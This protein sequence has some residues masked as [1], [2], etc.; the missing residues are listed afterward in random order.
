MPV[1]RLQCAFAVSIAL[2][3]VLAQSPGVRPRVSIFESQ[4][5]PSVPNDPLELVNEA[6]PVQNAEQRLA[7]TTLLANARPFLT[8]A[9]SHTI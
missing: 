1:H 8:C 5:Q 9:R 6:Q 2:A 7:A 4:A 3:P